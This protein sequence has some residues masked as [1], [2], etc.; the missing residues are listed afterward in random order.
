MIKVPFLKQQKLLGVCGFLLFFIGCHPKPTPAAPWVVTGPDDAISAVGDPALPDNGAATDVGQGVRMAVDGTSQKYY[1]RSHYS[2]ASGGSGLIVTPDC[3]ATVVTGIALT[4]GYDE[5]GRDPASFSLYGSEDGGKTL[6]PITLAHPVPAFTGRDKA[7][8]LSFSN[9]KAF[10][11]YKLIFPT[12]NGG[13]DMQVDEVSLLGS[14]TPDAAAQK[15]AQAAPPPKG[16]LTLWY[17]HPAESAMNEALP[18]GN[19]RMGGLVFGG[20][21][22]ERV[23]FNEDSLWTG[24]NN[25]SGDYGTMGSYQ[26]FGDILLHLDG[27][28]TPTH[29][30]RDLDIS[31]AVVH[32]SYRT[33]GITYRR[34]YFA[35]HPD[36]VLVIHFT[37]DRPGAYTGTLRLTDAHS[38]TV[39]SSDN[40]ITSTGTLS[41][42][43]KYAAKLAVLHTGGSVT[44]A[45]SQVEFH[46]CDSLT[47]LLGTGTD[48]VMDHARS[49]KSGELPL[50]RVASQVAAASA[51]PYK[52]LKAAHFQDYTSLF[53]RVH[54]DLGKS[55]AEARAM[56][57]N[58]RRVV[59]AAGGDPELEQLLFQYG[60]YLLIS[61]SRPGAL[62]ANL[63]GLWN[64]SNSPPWSSDYH[65]DINIQMNYWLAEV[66]NLSECHMPLFNLV[67]SQV[68][69]WRLATQTA[70]EY[71]LASGA[72]PGQGWDLRASF[73]I[74]GG[75]GWLWIKTANAW[76]LQDYWEH[77]VFTGDKQ[78]LQ[79]RAYP[80]MRETCQFWQDHLK[81]L[82]DDS[83]VVPNGWSPEHGDFEDGTSFNQE[84]VWDLFTNTI[85]ASEVLD[86]D[87][88]YRATLVSLRGKLLKPKVG[89]RGQ[90][91]EW[92]A[93]KD[94][95]NEHHRHTSH[96]VGVYPGHEFT[97]G[98]TPDMVKAA[99]T[100]LFER[101]NIGDV[102]EW[103]LAW[104]SALFARMGDG[105][106]A[107][108][109]LTQFFAARNSCSNLF[110]FCPP[111]QIDG[112]LGMTAAIAEMLLQSQN[113]EI[114]FLPALPTAWSKGSVAG[115]RARGGFTVG[116]TWKDGILLDAMVHS[117]NGGLCRIHSLTPLSVQSGES[118][119]LIHPKPGVYEFMTRQGATYRLSPGAGS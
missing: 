75:M 86:V 95:L 68:P 47:L 7:Q 30:Q 105:E 10:T 65:T 85:A 2:G 21:A 119:T 40:A 89:Q 28:D 83:L 92:A 73:N 58:Q 9:A 16:A 110:G 64:D 67:D 52:T 113:G 101:G 84:L 15:K 106:Q 66:A 112:D 93:D 54:L 49:Y 60:R 35:S 107:H 12:N 51:K 3:G 88:S 36:Q 108:G 33:N 117:L 43:L 38:G 72:Q 81:A 24:D 44:I 97:V 80:L 19:G 102:T 57:T 104:R 23:V 39:A 55:S 78:F 70:S 25:L 71:K 74:T 1:N 17:T 22:D 94:D 6:T 20:V 114:T 79:N 8:T 11:T 42:G 41:N 62:P 96:L 56:P 14:V 46:G 13:S 61:C 69:A 4:S 50:P 45:G 115:L 53:G 27:M 63:Q 116:M 91:Q 77:Y 31:Q 76:L 100:T 109:Q 29:Y 34:E 111:M 48:Y 99:K 18:I 87:A 37:A 98:E 26:A 5:P 90:L 32:V 103:A 82:P 59:A 118:V